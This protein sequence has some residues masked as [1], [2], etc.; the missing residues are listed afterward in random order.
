MDYLLVVISSA[1]KRMTGHSSR[2]ASRAFPMW[3]LFLA[4]T[5]LGTQ[6][7]AELGK[8]K[9][10]NDIGRCRAKC[11]EKYVF[12]PAT[13]GK[14]ELSE[15]KPCWK[16]CYYI[17][18]DNE[19]WKQMCPEAILC[20]K[21]CR[22]ACKFHGT[23]TEATDPMDAKFT[24]PPNITTELR[25]KMK[26]SI[27]WT[28]PT[29]TDGRSASDNTIYSLLKRHWKK[30]RTTGQYPWQIIAQTITPELEFSLRQ[31]GKEFEEFKL[32]AI[33]EK[34]KIAEIVF[35]PKM[36]APMNMV[37]PTSGY[38]LDNGS[39]TPNESSN[40]EVGSIIPLTKAPPLKLNVT[41]TLTTDNGTIRMILTWPAVAEMFTVTWGLLS[42]KAYKDMKLPD[43][44]KVPDFYSVLVWKKEKNQ[45]QIIFSL[46]GLTFNSHY[47]LD[48]LPDEKSG[49]QI[50]DRMD[51]W[52]PVCHVLDDT[53]TRCLT[54]QDSADTPSYTWPLHGNLHYDTYSNKFVAVINWDDPFNYTG[55]YQVFW[56]KWKFSDDNE[57]KGEAEGF[58]AN[59]DETEY[60]TAEIKLEAN[61]AYIIEAKT[62][63]QI[64]IG[65]GRPRYLFSQKLR[66]NTTDGEQLKLAAAPSHGTVQP[67]KQQKVENSRTDV[68]AIAVVSA[69][70]IF[71]LVVG[72]ILWKRCRS[73]I[74]IEKKVVASS[75][76]Y[77]S[78]F[79]EDKSRERMDPLLTV[80]DEWELDHC[81]IKFGSMLGQGAFGKVMTGVCDDQK[82]AIKVL[83]DNAPLSYREDFIAEITLMK[84]LGVHPHIVALIGACTIAEPLALVLEYMPHGN[85]QNFLKKCRLEGYIH[86]NSEGIQELQYRELTESGEDITWNITPSDMLS[87]ARQVALAME[88][89]ADKQ[90]VHRDLAARNVLVGP[91][92][93]VKLCD[94]GLSRDV[95]GTCEYHKITSGKLPLKWMALESLRDRIFTIQSD[96]WSFGILLWEI[97]TMGG[98]PYPSIALADLYVV[99]CN[100]YRMDSPSN[101]SP[102]VYDIMHRCWAENPA[103]RPTFTDLRESLDLLLGRELNYLQLDNIDV[104]IQPSSNSS[105]MTP[106][107]CLTVDDL[108]MIPFAD[109]ELETVPLTSSS[110]VL[111][112]PN[113]DVDQL[114]SSHTSGYLEAKPSGYLEAKPG[115]GLNG[116]NG[117]N[118]GMFTDVV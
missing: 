22:F 81:D 50:A 79:G 15:C 31:R 86:Q 20:G 71:V 68:I 58:A 2:D 36:D 76:S 110:E 82:V 47:F 89:I 69:I 21:G 83:K 6:G 43:C 102:E 88:Y 7:S 113:G 41:Q 26:Y 30:A 90:F 107:G 49:Y 93:L 74:A 32:I 72:I 37:E 109:R 112:L 40:I 24:S 18:K 95:Y 65:D 57:T 96:V 33:S 59:I 118:Q 23:A 77:K 46:D 4:L 64:D 101:C 19:V 56:Q 111:T 78:A 38:K 115:L 70:G 27:K 8:K 39:T 42:C 12:S 35:K 14:C 61:S 3:I 10:G 99:L 98:S 67:V 84:K 34:G 63:E 16:T 53:F 108:E 100:G 106:P 114:S 11:V 54:L 103:N 94:F 117:L 48:I 44:D 75:N 9:M 13:N 92:K 104:P 116:L 85:L 105:G 62:S 29:Y 60:S 66:I 51:I 17:Y 55:K 45:Q 25:K 28:A 97:V 80:R 1:L 91:D 5:L 87:F 52:T 73:E